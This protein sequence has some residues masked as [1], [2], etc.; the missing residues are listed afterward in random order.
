MDTE[1][2]TKEDKL[3]A[4]IDEFMTQYKGRTTFSRNEIYD[5][6]LDI[7]SIFSN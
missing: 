4:F 2:L 6:C 5:F 7:R 3:T 1:L